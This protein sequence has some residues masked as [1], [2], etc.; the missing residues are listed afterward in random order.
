M[1]VPTT[2][3]SGMLA[4]SYARRS[5]V[6]RGEVDGWS[7]CKCIVSG[8]DGGVSGDSTAE[9]KFVGARYMTG[10]IRFPALRKKLNNGF[11]SFF[12]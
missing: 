5:P 4:R 10:S 11:V 8:S 9:E 6:R 12:I 7:F 2:K 1:A 3:V